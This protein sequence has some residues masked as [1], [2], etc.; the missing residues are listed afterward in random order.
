MNNSMM[1]VKCKLHILKTLI[2]DTT[3]TVYDVEF[4]KYEIV[5]PRYEN[6][7]NYYFKIKNSICDK[8]FEELC[9]SCNI[10]RTSVN[11]AAEFTRQCVI[12]HNIVDVEIYDEDN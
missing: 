1:A 8:Y 3:V 10:E 5:N 6:I 12:V 11:S 2:D 4:K 9:K 7:N